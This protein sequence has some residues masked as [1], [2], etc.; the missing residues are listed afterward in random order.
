M[1]MKWNPS[2]V[3]VVML[4]ALSLTFAGC[5]GMSPAMSLQDQ[6]NALMKE[7]QQFYANK[8]YDQAVA[9][10]GEVVAKD[11]RY[12]QAYVGIAQSYI[13]KGNWADAIA[14][15]KK[16]YELAPKGQ[17]VTTV[18]GQ[19]FYGGGMEALKNGQLADSASRFVEYLKLDPSNVSAWLN[20]GKAYLGMGQFRDALNAFVQGLANGGGADRAELIRGLLDGGL[21]AFSRNDFR[22]AIDSLKEYIK[23]DAKNLSAYL[24]LAKAYW[25]SG[26][27]GNALDAFRKVL[28]LDPRQTEALRFLLGR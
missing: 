5:G 28:E 11:A 23:F 12:W 27:R 15:G 3:W 9:K 18:L 7:A 17:D 21:Q 20:V 22:T 16:A 2:R 1:F 24:N 10:F 25:E 6:I 8:Q 14:N 26:E 4:L 13:A 19:A